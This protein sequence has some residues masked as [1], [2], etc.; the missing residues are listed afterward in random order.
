MATKR[1][2]ELAA[3][4][5]GLVK[6]SQLELTSAGIAKRLA[7]GTLF[8]RYRG[9]YSLL[10]E[11]TR[12]G[13]WLA[14]VFAAGAGAALT[15]LN[16]AALYVGSR[17]Q[18]QGTTVAVP[19]RRRSQGFKLIVGLQ[20]RDIRMRNRIPVTSFERVLVD[21]PLH[22]EQRANL[23]HEAA[24]R[25]RFSHAATRAL[26]ARTPGRH[27][28]LERAI[29]MH[30]A[31]SAGTRS[32]LEDRFMALVRVERLPEPVINT[33]IHGVEVDFRWGRLCVE[34]DGPNHLRPATRD[35]DAANAAILARNGLTVLRFTEA[36][37]DREPRA[38]LDH[39]TRGIASRH[40]SRT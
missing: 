38:V 16:G 36:A 3:Q 10:P 17:F 7:A 13:E 12:E 28:R 9:V 19:K 6:G 20:P 33:H 22:P 8:R 24:V 39:L 1:Y 25:R 21:V 35:K 11:L 34:I 30:L 29:A 2:V 23:I 40:G 31:G 26:M 27:G 32:D 14:A 5:H 4:Q 15:A 37:I 18:P